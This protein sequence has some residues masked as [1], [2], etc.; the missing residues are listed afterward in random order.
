[1]KKTLTVLLVVALC[2]ACVQV[3]AACEQGGEPTVIEDKSDLI[4]SGVYSEAMS[5]DGMWIV[6][7]AESENAKFECKSYKAKLIGGGV[8]AQNDTRKS[9]V[10]DMVK[11][12][13]LENGKEMDIPKDYVD[14]IVKI[15]GHIVGYGVV[16]ITQTSDSPSSWT[17]RV[18]VA[19]VFPQVDGKYQNVLEK[20]VTDKIADA[21]ICG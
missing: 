13:P 16:E 15:D 5:V 8:T 6:F 18:L 9:I 19:K 12:C 20:Y 2:L 17:S 21:K 4:S 11:W 3:F 1:M 10:D 7:N 14:V